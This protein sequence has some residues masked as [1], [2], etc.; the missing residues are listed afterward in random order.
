MLC[1]SGTQ[2][3]GRKQSRQMSIKTLFTF[4][5]YLSHYICK[6][7]VNELGVTSS[8]LFKWLILWDNRQK[9]NVNECT[10]LF[11]MVFLFDSHCIAAGDYL[12]L[13]PTYF[14][15]ACALQTG[16]VS[17]FLQ[18]ISSCHI[19]ADFIKNW[20]NCWFLIQISCK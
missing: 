11:H 9:R 4:E 12:R 20:S 7:S 17:S 3:L 16:A 10:T 2:V 15:Y 18:L 1:F 8:G 14:T 19:L 6:P 13:G 5:I